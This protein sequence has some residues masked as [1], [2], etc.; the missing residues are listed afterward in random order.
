VDLDSGDLLY[1]IEHEMRS[2]YHP[3]FRKPLINRIPVPYPVD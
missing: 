2:L 1:R 3:D